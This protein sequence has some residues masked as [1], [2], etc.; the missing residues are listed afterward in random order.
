MR[1]SVPLLLRCLSVSLLL[2]GLALAEAPLFQSDFPP[3]EFSARREKVFDKIGDNALALIQGAAGVDGFNVFRQSAQFYYLCGVEAP[4]AYLLL[5]GRS[6]TTRLY[7]PHR[8]PGRERSLGSALSAED[9]ELIQK[10]TGIDSVHPV[11]M[12]SRHF[13]LVHHPVPVLY[14]PFSPAELGLHSRDESLTSQAAISSDP[15]DGRPSREGHF[16]QLLRTR[17][18][19]LAVRDLSPILDRL[20]AVKSPREVDVIRKASVIAGHAIME[21]IRSTKPGLREYQVQAPAW[22]VYQVNGARRA[23]Y[24][25]ITAG[26]TNAW[27]GHYSRNDD[28]LKSGDL[29]LM[30]WAPEYHYYTSDVTR[31]WPVN[32]KFTKSQRELCGFILEYRNTLIELIRPGVTAEQ[33]QLEARKKMEPVWRETSFSKEIYREGAR[34]ALDFRGHLSHPVGLSVHDVGH[35]RQWPLE[36][37][38]VIALDPMLWVPEENLYV[39]MEDTVVVTGDGVENFTDFMPSTMDEIE[40]LMKEE[41]I[42]SV[43]PPIDLE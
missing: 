4:H 18:P 26:G 34:K 41:G 36:P 35:Y 29:V 38:V 43:R 22:Y 37:G 8:D 42:V 2:A 13:S 5:D 33:I 24:S 10:R 21:A 7:L 23:G 15:W 27:H 30:D 3:E 25:A 20:R 11:E 1:F 16:I 32:G 6:R 12:L 40:A 14:T 28:V 17:F 39:R 19:S 9:A 31:M